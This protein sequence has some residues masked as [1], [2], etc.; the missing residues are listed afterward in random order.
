MQQERRELERC[1]CR[2][3]ARTHA[4]N[5]H[6]L[7]PSMKAEKMLALAALAALPASCLAD[8]HVVLEQGAVELELR[9]AATHEDG[10]LLLGREE[11]TQH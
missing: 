3:S 5:A 10:Q 8:I 1:W 2:C 9:V 4:Y 7:A 11:C 6:L